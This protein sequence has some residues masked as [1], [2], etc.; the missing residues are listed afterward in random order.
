[1][2]FLLLCLTSVYIRVNFEFSEI[3][4]NMQSISVPLYAFMMSF[5][6][7]NILVPS[8]LRIEVYLVHL[9]SGEYSLASHLHHSLLWKITF[10]FHSYSLRYEIHLTWRNCGANNTNSA[11]WLA[12]GGFLRHYYNLFSK[13]LNGSLSAT[14]MG[15]EMSLQRCHTHHGIYLL[16]KRERRMDRLIN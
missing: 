15:Q 3:F 7:L 10:H 8:W 13:R 4:I 6:L 11:F 5:A 1:M 12:C 14:F 2:P 16:I 9:V